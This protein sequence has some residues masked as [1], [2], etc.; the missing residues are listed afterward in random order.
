[1]KQLFYVVTILLISNSAFSQKNFTQSLTGI[2]WVKIES[3]TNVILKTHSKNEIL[4]SG[5]PME[6]PE[7]AK[8]LKLLGEAGPDNTGVGMNVTKNGSTLMVRNIK[9][10]EDLEI[11][12]PKSTNVSVITKGFGDIKINDFDGE[13]ETEANLNGGITLTNVTG[14]VTANTLNGAIKIAFSK[15]NQESPIS[16]T[17]INGEIDISM[18]ANSPANISVDSMHGS[19]YT[20]FDLQ[21]PKKD[22]LTTISTGKIKG[23]LNNGGVLMKL[24]TINSDIYLRGK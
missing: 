20:D 21:I 16:V 3:S 9:K 1:M 18:P 17:T 5:S 8:G 2:E 7:K 24:E 10:G 22:G 4:I 6:I 19:I 23:T 15:L 11:F 13:I 12:L 14:P